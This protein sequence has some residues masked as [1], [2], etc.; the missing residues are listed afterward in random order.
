MLITIVVIV[1]FLISIHIWSFRAFRVWNLPYVIQWTLTQ[2]SFL[3]CTFC[4]YTFSLIPRSLVAILFLLFTSG[5]WGKVLAEDTCSIMP[6]SSCRD[7]WGDRK[8]APGLTFH[9]HC[10][11]LHTCSGSSFPLGRN[12][13]ASSVAAE[14]SLVIKQLRDVWFDQVAF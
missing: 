3:Y 9:S 1:Y 8:E 12:L 7:C 13:T 11:P 14:S 6:Q 2:C 5:L 10:L 4:C